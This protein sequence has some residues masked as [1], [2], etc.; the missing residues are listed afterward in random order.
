MK[1]WNLYFLIIILF[2][3]TAQNKNQTI[4]HYHNKPKNTSTMIELRCEIVKKA[5]VNQKGVTN[6]DIQEYYL[7]CSVDDY[8][9]KFC[10][11]KVSK[12][13]ILAFYS[14]KRFINPIKVN[15]ELI[16]GEW[17]NCNDEIK[18]SRTGRYVRIIE[19]LDANN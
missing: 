11:C 4:N 1:K 5:F 13:D 8:F 17:D 7:R 10:E 12:Q 9:I 15:A 16:D 3:C 2:G 18:A 19:I 14:D 6:N